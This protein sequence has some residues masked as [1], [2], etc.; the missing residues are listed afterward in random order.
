MADSTGKTG[1]GIIF[2]IGNGDTPT[3]IFLPIANATSINPTGRDAEE[4]DFTHLMS[5]GGFREFRQGFK[6][7]GSIGIE[8][9]FSPEE[10]SHVE[11]LDLWDSGEV[12]TWRIDFTG[13][14]WDWYLEG[15]GYVQ[16]PGD[17]TI[18]VDNPI[19]GSATVRCTGK[20]NFVAA[21]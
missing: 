6:D 21:P 8:Y 12:V 10:D 3:E 9:Q 16:N 19:A 18:D 17:L 11:L 14:G 4:I 7:A 5:T 1:R 20:P 15:K 2:L 13:A